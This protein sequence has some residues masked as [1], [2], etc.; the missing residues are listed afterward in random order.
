MTA[1]DDNQTPATV[2]A[3]STGMTR[4]DIVRLLIGRRVDGY[5]GGS[6][7]W[8]NSESLTAYIEA[9]GLRV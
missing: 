3:E 9:N 1:Y 8:V 7:Y 6:D 2:L 4:T 5:R